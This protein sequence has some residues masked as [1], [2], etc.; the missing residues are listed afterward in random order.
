MIY[1]ELRRA[2][3][4]LLEINKYLFSLFIYYVMTF[5]KIDMCN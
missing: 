1:L 4:P 5:I 3:F 2:F